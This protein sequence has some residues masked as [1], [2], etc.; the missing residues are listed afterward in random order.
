V[1]VAASPLVSATTGSN[2][3]AEATAPIDSAPVSASS[4][5]VTE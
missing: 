2:A 3:S 1:I 4:Q 5:V